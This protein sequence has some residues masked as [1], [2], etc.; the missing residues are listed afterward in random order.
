MSLQNLS[1][2]SV[3][4][5]IAEFDT[6]GREAFLTKYGFSRA[7]GYFLIHEGRRYDSKAIAGAAHAYATGRLLTRNEFSGGEAT[8]R[9]AMER[10]GF[11]V[12]APGTRLGV[13]L[14]RDDGTEIDAH[15]YVDWD[16]VRNS[17][18]FES[19]GGTKGTT[20]ARNVDYAEGLRLVLERLGRRDFVLQSTLLDT[21]E[22]ALL[23]WEKRL[24]RYDGVG[25]E[26]DPERTRWVT[27]ADAD[28]EDVRLRIMRAQGANS[29]RRIRLLI[30]S[31]I[32]LQNDEWRN[33][34]LDTAE[35][36]AFLQ[37]G[38]A[39]YDASTAPAAR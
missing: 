23:G 8:V 25:W 12:E 1:H 29:T 4:Q 20:H 9:K 35:L 28:P 6:I 39:V 30:A 38:G 5:A 11:Q 10:L 22:T 14:F 31:R 2:E 36:Q 18:V 15:F 26:R 33:E 16:G 13:P 27:L 37:R 24:L 21:R 17:V 32:K 3:L 34:R 19:R 7:R